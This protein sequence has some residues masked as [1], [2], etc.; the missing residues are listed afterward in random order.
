MDTTF[1]KLISSALATLAVSSGALA[2]TNP[3]PP[4]KQGYGLTA[5][6]LPAAYNAPA[7]FKVENTWDLFLTGSF[8]YWSA[9]QDAMEL[10]VNTT[11]STSYLSPSNGSFVKQN[12]SYRPGFKLGLGIDCNFDDWVAFVEYTWLRQQTSNSSETPPSDSRGGTPLWLATDWYCFLP[13]AGGSGP[14]AWASDFNSKWR[15]HIDLLD[16]TLSRPFYRGRQITV[17]PF[18]GMRAAWI[19]QNFRM[20]MS[21]INDN[22]PT[23]IAWPIVSHNQSNSWAIGPRVGLDGHYLIGAGFRL[24]GDIAGS[25]LYTRYTS[26]SHREDSTVTA[27]ATASFQTADT[28]ILRPMADMKLGLGWGAYTDHRDYHFDLLFSYDFNMMWGQNMM[29]SLVNSG[30]LTSASAAG[31]LHLQ[32][33][34]ITAR[35]D[36]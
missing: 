14:F 17:T 32:G 5:D 23:P 25:L 35:F 8:L 2:T 30:F 12:V 3:P 34:N 9:Q 31:D 6:Q 22:P 4:F 15:T 13:G 33:L 36:F 21:Y 7:R 26:V 27:A 11:F 19:R 1:I 28:D 16:A 20:S 18:G 29:R 24:E 10:A